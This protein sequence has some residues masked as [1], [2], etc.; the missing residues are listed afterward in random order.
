MA[1]RAQPNDKSPPLV[2]ISALLPSPLLSLKEIA[3]LFSALIPETEVT[4]ST[5]QPEDRTASKLTGVFRFWSDRSGSVDGQGQGY[6][7]M[8]GDRRK[9]SETNLRVIVRY[10][11]GKN[12]MARSME[13]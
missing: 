5:C 6:S 3:V 13:K 7:T 2:P 12:Y 10:C 8:G 1:Y 4:A 11:S 9:G